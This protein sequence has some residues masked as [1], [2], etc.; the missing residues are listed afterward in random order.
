MEIEKKICLMTDL[1]PI[2]SLFVPFS[3]YNFKVV[4]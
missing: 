2:I 3:P 4:F 1:V